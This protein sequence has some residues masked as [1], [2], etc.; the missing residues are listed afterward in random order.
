MP[1]A[2]PDTHES[3]TQSPTKFA[4]RARPATQP[5]EPEST[6]SARREQ[7]ITEAAYYRAEKRGFE[8]G[9]E[10]EDWMA[11][12]QEIDALVEAAV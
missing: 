4:K 11:A 1:T 2:T 9:H 6:R 3:I 8:A 7:H 10:L 12:E 5:A